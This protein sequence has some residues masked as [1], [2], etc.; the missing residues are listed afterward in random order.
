MTAEKRW[1]IV[2]D[3]TPSADDI[4]FTATIEVAAYIVAEMTAARNERGEGDVEALS[5]WE[6]N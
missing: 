6:E 3:G 1:R 5:D 4:M 2:E